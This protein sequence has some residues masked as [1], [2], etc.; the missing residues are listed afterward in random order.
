M[1]IA[2]AKGD[3]ITDDTDALLAACAVGGDIQIPAGNFVLRRPLRLKAGTRITRWEGNLLYQEGW[4]SAYAI[5]GADWTNP[6]GG[7]VIDASAGG[8]LIFDGNRN[9]MPR[10]G[11]GIIG[12]GWQMIKTRV[13][14][15]MAS[16]PNMDLFQYEFRDATNCVLTR[17]TGDLVSGFEGSDLFHFSKNS[18]GN[19]LNHCGGRSGDDLISFTHENPGWGTC[20]IANN[21]VNG[22]DYTT[23]GHSG[24]KALSSVDNGS[25]IRD[26]IV[27]GA[28]FHVLKT[29]TNP[30]QPIIIQTKPNDRISNISAPGC[31]WLAA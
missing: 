22:G 21:N 24:I 9:T 11:F 29:G 28:T 3:G 26:C 15:G 20:T 14:G 23:I 18:S 4:V 12:T 8:K 16:G 13:E 27:S 5:S 25:V 19:K 2:N 17:C 31:T 10:K 6:V 30:G 1:S 7:V